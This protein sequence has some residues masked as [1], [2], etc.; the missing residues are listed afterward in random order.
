VSLVSRVSHGRSSHA[1][2]TGAVNR[3]LCKRAVDVRSGSE[4]TFVVRRGATQP[5]QDVVRGESKQRDRHHLRGGN[6]AFFPAVA[7]PG[8]A[9]S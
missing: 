6:L 7:P 5:V 2:G 8:R 1:L 3:R 4:C 9:P